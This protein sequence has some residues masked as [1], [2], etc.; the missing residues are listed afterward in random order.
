[1][2]VAA[3]RDVAF[4][5]VAPNSEITMAH[6]NGKTVGNVL[7]RMR[8]DK[9]YS[10][11]PLSVVQVVSPSDRRVK[12]DISGVDEDA[13]M[14][15]LQ[16]IEVVQYRYTPEWQAIR[17]FDNKLVRGVLAQQVRQVIALVRLRYALVPARLLRAR[18]R[19][20]ARGIEVGPAK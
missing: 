8:E 3:N 14:H 1:M 17:G 15:R 19:P 9:V 11:V 18:S 5:T 7:F 10:H 6:G 20:R 2:T 12:T 16:G 13:I 4:S